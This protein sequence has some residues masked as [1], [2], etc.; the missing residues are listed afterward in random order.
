MCD[1]RVGERVRGVAEVV[2]VRIIAGKYG[3]RIIKSPGTFKTHPMSERARGAI[4]NM[5]REEIVGARVLDGF[6]G[7]GAIGLEALS[8]GAEF[9]VFVERDWKTKRILKGNVEKLGAQEESKV[10]GSGLGGWLNSR[11]GE[12]KFDVIFA[13]PP[14]SDPQWNLVERLVGVLS[15]DGVLVVSQA[16]RTEE[17]KLAGAK[18]V[19]VREYADAAV[20]FYRKV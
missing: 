15:D 8:R 19:D 2:N 17:E 14:Y 3:G 9:V 1:A 4:F 10:I 12:E 16:S 5:L 11:R 18:V 7:T 20:R 13:D 6:A